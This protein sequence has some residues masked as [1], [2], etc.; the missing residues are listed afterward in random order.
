MRLVL[1]PKADVVEEDEMV[2]EADEGAGGVV[3][4]QRGTINRTQSDNISLYNL[5]DLA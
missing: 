1:V 5:I 2:A 3:S 4:S